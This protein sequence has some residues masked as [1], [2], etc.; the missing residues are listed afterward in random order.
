MEEFLNEKKI[1]V[2][3]VDGSYGESE[4]GRKF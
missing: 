4:Y 3:V 1:I 2:I